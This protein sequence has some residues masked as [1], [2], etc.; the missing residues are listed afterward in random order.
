[1]P[2]HDEIHAQAV[3]HVPSNHPGCR[4]EHAPQEP[5]QGVHAKL[6]HFTVRL[7]MSQLDNLRQTIEQFFEFWRISFTQLEHVGG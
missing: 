4:E 7:H 1:V 2:V 6:S 3:A 5:T